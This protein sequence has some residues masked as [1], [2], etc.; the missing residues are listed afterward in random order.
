VF[1]GIFI[2]KDY[3]FYVDQNKQNGFS[4]MNTITPINAL[5]YNSN[6]DNLSTHGLHPRF[7]H[8]L[9][10]LPML[11]GPL[12]FMFILGNVSIQSKRKEEEKEKRSL[13]LQS[14]IAISLAT[15][16]A[17][18][19][20]EPRFLLPM[21]GPLIINYGKDI[22]QNRW[23]WFLWLLFNFILGSFFCGF[24]QAGVVPSLLNVGDDYSRTSNTYLYYHTYMPPT[25]LSRS[26]INSIYDLKSSTLDALHDSLRRELNN[27]NDK[28]SK[29][30]IVSPE[31]SLFD[32]FPTHQV[33][34]L[35]IFEQNKSFRPHFST[36]HLPHF[37]SMSSF[38]SSLELIRYRITCRS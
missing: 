1:A 21:L 34:E 5:I 13:S 29:V 30:F 14:T 38:W 26:S 8:A 4:W 11:F 9:V 31:L 35:F 3:Y 22:L 23:I 32:D 20:Q 16:S 17:A 12:Y 18:P 25:F 36:E 6:T 27:C 7:T 2:C 37:Q 10:N 28:S 15:L 33:N 24:H 19:H